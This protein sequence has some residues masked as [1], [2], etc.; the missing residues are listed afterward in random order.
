MW[1][2]AAAVIESPVQVPATTTKYTQRLRHISNMVDSSSENSVSIG[3]SHSEDEVQVGGGI[4]I[5]KNAF[6]QFLPT[7]S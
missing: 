6:N 3:G 5:K 2:N 7:T 1:N 4:L